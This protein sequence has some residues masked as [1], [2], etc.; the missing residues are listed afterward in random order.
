[1]FT[2]NVCSH[3]NRKLYLLDFGVTFGGS[4]ATLTAKPKASLYVVL[5]RI[6]KLPGTCWRKILIADRNYDWTNK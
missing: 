3:K 2:C 1:M 5:S 6:R 4:V